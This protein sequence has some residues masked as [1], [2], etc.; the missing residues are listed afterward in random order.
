[1]QWLHVFELVSYAQ[2]STTQ[3]V[4]NFKAFAISGDQKPEGYDAAMYYT[5]EASIQNAQVIVS[6]V[7]ANTNWKMCVDTT[8]DAEAKVGVKKKDFLTFIF[9]KTIS[10]VY[11]CVQFL[12]I[13]I[14]VLCCRRML[15]G[16]LSVRPMICQWQPLLTMSTVPSQ[17]SKPN[18]NGTG[19]QSTW[20]RLAKGD[21]SKE[22]ILKNKTAFH[23]E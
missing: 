19:L 15:D 9:I 11:L 5:P 20:P 3:A 18:Y 21:F 10:S 22:S 12:L 6:Q 14:T 2:N 17:S 1:M 7:G 4:F 8:L 13:M 16:V 23:H